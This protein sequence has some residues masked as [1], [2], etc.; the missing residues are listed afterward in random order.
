MTIPH[1]PTLGLV[2]AGGTMWALIQIFSVHDSFPLT[3]ISYAPAA[4]APTQAAG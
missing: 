4:I 1:P 3:S 2:L